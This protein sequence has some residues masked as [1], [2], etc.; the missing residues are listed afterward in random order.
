MTD[1]Q[2]LQWSVDRELVRTVS[3]LVLVTAWL[4]VMLSLLTLLPGVDS[5]VPRTPVT[6]V[7]IAGAV[8]TVAL[9]GLLMYIAPMLASLVLAS[10]DGPQR[11]VENLAAVVYWFVVL[12]AVIV[13]HRGFAGVVTPFLDGFEWVY[14]VTFLLAALPVVAFIGARLYA[15]LD[16][17]SE[18]VAD[19]VAGVGSDG[20]PSAEVNER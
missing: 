8:V 16:P 9:V 4:V 7:A 5:L 2:T 3:K 20:E 18:L 10:L 11:L 12:V 13:A 14:D 15:S 6:F 17:G 1:N 19:R